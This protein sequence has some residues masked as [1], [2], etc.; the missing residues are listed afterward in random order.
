MPNPQNPAIRLPPELYALLRARA[1]AEG[2]TIQAEGEKLIG[3]ALGV[4]APDPL[5]AVLM[6]PDGLAALLRTGAILKPEIPQE[7]QSDPKTAPRR[8]E[9]PALQRHRGWGHGEIW[10]SR[11][12]RTTS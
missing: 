10:L 7:P 4:P 1:E 8:C 11:R 3:A 2:M 12:E 9:V 5:G 6:R